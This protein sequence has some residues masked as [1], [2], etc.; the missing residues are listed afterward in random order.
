MANSEWKQRNS[1][2]AL[3]PL[4]T[5]YSHFAIRHFAIRHFAIRLFR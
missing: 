4:A 3:T 1:V 2:T 5:R